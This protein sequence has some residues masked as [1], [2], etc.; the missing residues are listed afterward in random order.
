MY[1]TR[2]RT[3]HAVATACL[4]ALPLSAPLA[5]SLRMPAAQALSG[6]SYGIEFGQVVTFPSYENA[7]VRRDVQYRA[8]LVQPTGAGS[9]QVRV[10]SARGSASNPHARSVL[11]LRFLMGTTLG[12]TYGDSGKP[13]SWAAE[14]PAVTFADIGGEMSLSLMLDPLFPALPARD[15]RSGATW[16]RVWTRSVLVGQHIRTA[17]VRTRYTIEGTERAGG[18]TAWKVQFVTTPVSGATGGQESTGTMLV[19]SDGVLRELMLSEA[20]GGDDW[21]F[22]TES[23]GFR[24]RDTIRVTLRAG[25]GPARR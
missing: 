6:R 5:Q 18:A 14:G 8:T 16:E 11:D 9:I 10:D 4:L 12:V 25:S 3:A 1:S 15:V 7:E 23:V 20:S 21:V 19:G 13:V 24:Q 22:G 2:S 17:Q